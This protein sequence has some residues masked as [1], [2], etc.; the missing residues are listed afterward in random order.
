MQEF[1][2]NI[3]ESQLNDFLKTK[4]GLT[5]DRIETLFKARPGL[6]GT[7]D[8]GDPVDAHPPRQK[9]SGELDA[10]W[11]QDQYKAASWLSLT[12]GVRFT[13]FSGLVT[14]TAGSPSSSSSS[15]SEYGGYRTRGFAGC[16]ARVAGAPQF[17]AIGE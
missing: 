15:S 3:N 7:N 17:P 10:L 11:I 4:V 6:T 8:S 14:E 2:G 16:P 13:R 1:R 5:A 12:A 9:V